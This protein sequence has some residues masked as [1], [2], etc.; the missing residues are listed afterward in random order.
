MAD[1]TRIPITLE[2]PRTNTLGGNVF[3]AP[4]FLSTADEDMAFWQMVLDVDGK[5]YGQVTVPNTIGATPAAKIILLIAANA[6]TGVSRL[7]VSAIPSANGEGLN[8][9]KTAITA[10]DITMPTTAYELEEVSFTLPTTGSFPI[11]GKDVL[12]VEI[13]H[14]GAHANDTLAANTLVKAAYLELDLS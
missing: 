1:T 14:E 7:S 13:F 10:Q 6:T 11:V 3:Y 4:D 8:R 12:D 2:L 9:A 5:L